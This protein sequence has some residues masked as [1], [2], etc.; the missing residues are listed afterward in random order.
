MTEYQV[1]LAETK[2]ALAI[3]L[4]NA[5]DPDKAE[6]L[7]QEALTL[8]RKLARQRSADDVRRWDLSR[9]LYTLG[10]IYRTVPK[11]A[12]LKEA[13]AA[14][15]E[16]VQIQEKLVAEHGGDPLYQRDLAKTYTGL[17]LAY[18]QRKRDDK[19]T[20]VYNKAAGVWE[21][22][23]NK[24]P[25]VPEY[26][27]GRRDTFFCLG[28]ANKI[29]GNFKAAEPW[30]TKAVLCFDVKNAHVMSSVHAKTSLSGA[31]WERAKVRSE[32]KQHAAA[33]E[34]WDQA[35]ALAPQ[36]DNA[37]IRLPRAAT[38][39]RL[40]KHVEAIKEAD[41]LASKINRKT[42]TSALTL[43]RFA[44][45]YALS[46]AVADSKD[47]AD[48]YAAEAVKLLEE[49]KNLGF[50]ASPGYNLLKTDEA[51]QSLRDRPEFK[52]LTIEL[53]LQ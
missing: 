44:R 49:A 52:K 11:N 17:G 37:A 38:L 47:Q 28:D 24:H 33:L 41:E 13:E 51:L 14:Y 23:V 16:A 21:T 2:V 4:K 5:G 8:Q 12:K 19:A 26:I 10:G 1:R 39:A 50:F 30:Y 53:K 46:I 18:M 20:E 7:C 22:L 15:D 48:R 36:A 34:D 42:K 3:L 29:V 27:I 9:G 32:L 6:A 25:D 40:G 35:L 31:Y 43:Y 45:V